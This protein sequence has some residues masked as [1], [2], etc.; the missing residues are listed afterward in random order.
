[1]GAPPWAQPW[2]LLCARTGGQGPADCPPCLLAG[3]GEYAYQQP[4]TEQT[5][6]RSF[7]ESTQ[8]Y[9]EGGKA[10]RGHL[11][12]AVGRALDAHRE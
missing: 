7:E 10:C 3:H 5:Y 11:T 1:M 9:Y 6:D 8:H 12:P 4:Y 2:T